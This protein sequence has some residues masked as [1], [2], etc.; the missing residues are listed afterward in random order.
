MRLK[1]K[2]ALLT[3]AAAAIEGELMGFGGA[4]AHL[5]VREG[6]KVVL[7]DIR[8]ELGERAAQALRDGGAEARYQ[9]LDVTSEADWQRVIADTMAAYG[10]LDVVFNNA[11]ISVPTKVEKMTE[12]EWDLE[13]SVHAKGVFLG[14]K[15]AIPAMRQGGGGSIIN[16]S[17]IMGIVGSPTSP[18]YSAAKGA[19]R[20]FT[21]T[22]AL[23]YAKEN[24]RVNSVHPGYAM[25]PLTAERFSDPGLNAEL[26][27]KTPM[28]RL[29][30][31]E[32][33]ANGVLF[34]ASDESAW[35]TGSELVIDGGMTAQ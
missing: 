35:M 2:V 6:A 31:A 21:K 18:A 8:D 30:T 9:H 1:D 23:Q 19:I 20:I 15:H 13:L 11:G 14:T 17:S 24:I 22:A 10:R 32:D 5:F 27:G 28:G 16:T 33:I 7:T 3:G 26:V 12:E 4:A 34:L 25:T 29:G